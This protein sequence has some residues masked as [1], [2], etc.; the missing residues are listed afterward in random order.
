MPVIA[1][2]TS[3]GSFAPLVGGD[4]NGDGRNNDRAFVFDPTNPVVMADTALATIWVM[5]LFRG[6]TLW[7]LTDPGGPEAGF[8]PVWSSSGDELLFSFGDDRRMRLFRQTLSGV[9]ACV[10]DTTGPK[11]PTDWSDDGRFITYNSQ[12]PDYR[13]QHIW[14]ASPF[15]EDEA[16]PL[17]QHPYQ[18]GSA[19]F[20]PEARAVGG[21][22]E[23]QRLMFLLK[24]QEGMTCEEIA[25]TMGTS[26]GTVKKTL[27]RVVDR[28][29]QHFAMPAVKD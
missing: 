10:V 20:A 24:H 29:R 14:V 6:G 21:V 27:F 16:Y 12:E 7:R 13:Y 19:R 28:L 17:I 5:D 15:P 2:A 4:I 23:R 1:R 11:F 22:P 9:P 26:V 8:C 3:G 25:D 18:N